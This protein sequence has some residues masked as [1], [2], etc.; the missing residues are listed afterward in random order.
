MVC[1]S[2][3]S[4][5][6]IVIL[7]I[8]V[9][10]SI[11]CSKSKTEETLHSNINLKASADTLLTVNDV[12]KDSILI[13]SIR[14]ISVGND[15]DI[16]LLDN[17][18]KRVFRFN[19]VGEYKS[20]YISGSGR[21]P[22][23]VANPN[24]VFVDKNN[25]VY[26]TDRNERKFYIFDEKGKLFAEN[27]LD[28]MPSRIAAFDT[29]RV[30]VTGFRFSYKDSNIVQSYNLENSEYSKKASFG[31]RTPMGNELLANMSGFSDFISVAE[32]KFI[33][34]R[35]YPYHFDI[36][37]KDLTL[38]HQEQK[39]HVAFKPPFRENGV[40]NLKA[41]GREILILKDW[42]LFRYLV[43]EKSFFDIYDPNFKYINTK[44]ASE[45]GIK[46]DGKYFAS[47]VIKNEV[48]VVYEDPY[49]NVM[50]Y[51]F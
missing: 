35:F 12:E 34:N 25:F 19:N 18:N 2:E 32:N 26:L 1:R 23:E 46:E 42:V 45:L 47:Y 11:G 48:I 15:G 13:G 16:Y 43:D 24:A 22:G 27:K 3:F 39:E 38:I 50:R 10:L 30:F 6:Y 21:G 7:S 49:F 37:D 41:V 44:S 36:Y 17:A 40:V 8:V 4:H 9:L 51:S 29:S 31:K 33:L 28:L 5:R 14:G 20:N